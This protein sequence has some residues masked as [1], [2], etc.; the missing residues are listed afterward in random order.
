MA[1]SAGRGQAPGR[2]RSLSWDTGQR[3]GSVPDG[4]GVAARA[5]NAA[6][7]L[8]VAAALVLQ[9]WIAVHL[10]SVP[11]S[12]VVGILAGT[13]LIG[14]VVRVLS[15]FTVLSNIL[16]AV[17]SAQ[18]ARTPERDG[19]GWRVL[20]LMSLF[21]I[22][23]TGIVYTTVLA[24]VHDPH[25]WQETT[26]NTVFHYVVPTAMVLGW[27]L[28]GPRPRIT[29]RAVRIALL[30]PVAWVAYTLVRGEAT[31]WYPYPFVDVA[32][33]GYA[34]VVVSSIGVVAAFAVVTALLAI[35]D[36]VLPAAPRVARPGARPGG[37]AV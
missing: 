32:S 6:I 13:S 7:A 15:F 27:L 37:P 2:G 36:R 17:T 12:H 24:K 14:R 34:R 28:F 19:A 21:S 30:W 8:L 3:F 33:H 35:G 20:R 31:R 18:L 22:A 10:P 1:P 4:G 23:V 26:T 11:P 9:L 5:L 25:G 16:S 29:G